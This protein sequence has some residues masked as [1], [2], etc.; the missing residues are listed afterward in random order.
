MKA[1]RLIVVGDQTFTIPQAAAQ[2][3]LAVGTIRVR[4]HRGW[5]DAQ[6]VGK[7]PAPGKLYRKPKTRKVHTLVPHVTVSAEAQAA[8]TALA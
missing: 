6:A 1:H 7:D 8:E 5:T 2:F 4:L 3:G